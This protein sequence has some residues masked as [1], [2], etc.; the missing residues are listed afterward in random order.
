MKALYFAYGSNMDD[1]QM[2]GRC[3]GAER[4]GR[5]FLEDHKLGFVG[6]S[7]TWYGRGV[8]TAVPADGERL[9]G[10]LWR[11]EGPHFRAL[12]RCEGVPT[13][14][15]RER[16]PVVRR[17]ACEPAHVYF[18]NSPVPNGPSFVYA[19]VIRKAHRRIGVSAAVLRDAVGM[20]ITL[21]TTRI[22]VYGTLMRGEGNHRLLEGARRIGAARTTP[23][24]S[25]VSLGGFPGLVRGG[26]L[27]VRGELYDVDRGT[28]QD[29]DR[30]EGHPH[31]YRRQ[32]I[33]LDDG[34]RA[35]AYLLTPEQVRGHEPIASGD[36]R[37]ARRE[38]T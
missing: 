21:A 20:P 11:V 25:F 38:Y 18:A 6:R 32:P 22:F 35:I 28:L 31:F 26:R 9:P 36:W 7:Y 3:P 33:A 10:V 12:D 30:L 24:F 13:S 37:K 29:L 19:D 14:Y 2:A 1:A 8:A 5:A 23:E 4:V 15:V 16:V 17:G 27:S 34:G